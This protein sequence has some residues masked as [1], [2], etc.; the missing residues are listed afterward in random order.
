MTNS[1]NS[2]SV[3][4]AIVN[5]ELCYMQIG[6]LCTSSLL[7]RLLKCA[8]YVIG[9]R[10]DKYALQLLQR[11]LSTYSRCRYLIYIGVSGVE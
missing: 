4:L 6:A 9:E 5:V 1:G 2:S 8:V 10:A 7:F 3:F 11:G